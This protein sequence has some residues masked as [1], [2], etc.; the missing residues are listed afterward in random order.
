MT[1]RLLLLVTALLA[2][3]LIPRARAD[4][5][6]AP[7]TKTQPFDH[8][9]AWEGRGNRVVP[10]ARPTVVQDFG[11]SKTR[12]AGEAGE[13][14]GRVTRASEP[15][16]YAQRIAPKTLDDRLGASGTFALTDTTPGGGIFFGFFNAK[17]PGAGGRPI[18]SL[19]MHMDAER[20]GGRLAVRLITAE[21]Q[22]RGTF[23]TPFIPGRF[24]PTPIR[25]DGTRYHWTL[26]YDPDA[27]GGR[28]RFTFTL[29]GDAPKPG[30]LQT[31]GMPNAWREEARRRFPDTTTFA[32]D[33]PD[34]YRKQ[35]AT[36][37]HFGL[38]NMMKPGGHLTVYFDDLA[39]DGKAQDFATDPGW[40]AQG[41]RATY[42]ATDVAAAHDFGFSNTNHA[43]G[44]RGGEAGGT[45]WRSERWGYYA[46]RVG[47]L[48]FD[49]RLEASGTVVLAVGA[50]DA[51]M[52]FG[53]F[54]PDKDGQG[55]RDPRHAGDFLGIKV[56]GPTRAG[57]YFLPA[58]TVDENVRG[59]PNTGPII[60][61]GKVYRWSLTYDP[62]ANNGGGAI[63]AT[64][65]DESVTHNL[66]PGQKAKATSARL[67]H[68]GLFS[69]GPGGQIVKLY[70]DDLSYTAGSAMRRAP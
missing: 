29:R 39:C 43:G 6:T 19:G 33:L 69:T 9:P 52:C 34:G 13:M 16:F 32:V 23:V 67:D 35:G 21:N 27:A 26:D 30:D 55:S 64:L 8:D 58:F 4:D 42:Q 5:R 48:S 62:S 65:G 31:P 24:R 68:F 18:G 57:H 2:A 47:P 36:F 41:N 10:K 50:P 45:L 22:S 66:R 1:N 49:D 51:D 7:L 15:A 12:F 40:D 25:N 28:G 61:P 20:G 60:R 37:D 53:W 11:Y 46:D 59:L 63:T 38:M 54:R 56:G 70:L 14:G 17:Q 3:V 44:A